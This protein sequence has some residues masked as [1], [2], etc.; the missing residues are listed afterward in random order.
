MVMRA[1]WLASRAREAFSEILVRLGLRNFSSIVFSLALFASGQALAQPADAGG[2]VAA[3]PITAPAMIDF[4]QGSS[5]QPYLQGSGATLSAGESALAMVQWNR[6]VDAMS[7]SD[8]G[9]AGGAKGFSSA[10]LVAAN[11]WKSSDPAWQDFAT[12]AT[13][14][15]PVPEPSTYGAILLGAACAWVAF[16][17]RSALKVSRR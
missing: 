13:V 8:G 16:R 9:Q 1:N 12:T 15:T 2:G 17:R 6:A 4:P 5:A 14:L 3:G 10:S 7:A 11:S